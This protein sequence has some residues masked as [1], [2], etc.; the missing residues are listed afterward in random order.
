MPTARSR[1]DARRVNKI[2]E[3]W[4]QT[5]SRVNNQ[6]PSTMEYRDWWY[7]RLGSMELLGS[8]L[9]D[10]INIDLI[11]ESGT[12]R[13][14][15][16]PPLEY[17]EGMAKLRQLRGEDFSTQPFMDAFR[18]LVAQRSIR[19]VSR[20]TGLSKTTIHRLLQGEIAPSGEEM[21]KVAA[22]FFKKGSYFKEYRTAIVCAL[23]A[24]LLDDNPERSIAVVRRLTRAS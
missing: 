18:E 2:G 13:R 12:V 11:L 23:T 15:S 8:I 7:E 1:R 4:E 9:H 19:H 5:V 14:G 17:I 10:I 20:L 16:R 24:R 22:G 21:E 6:F 3:T